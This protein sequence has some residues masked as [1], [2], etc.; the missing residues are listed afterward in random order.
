MRMKAIVE[1]VTQEG[2][3]A[4]R[5]NPSYSAN[6]IV[7]T[8]EVTSI[9]VVCVAN[10]PLFLPLAGL[11]ECRPEVKTLVRKISACDWRCDDAL[12]AKSKRHPGENEER[13]EGFSGRGPSVMG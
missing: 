3:L 11:S 10:V 4:G 13:K 6:N 12:P 1:W 7:Y 8:G 5:D 9:E 2:S